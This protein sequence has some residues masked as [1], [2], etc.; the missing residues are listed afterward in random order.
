LDLPTEKA[1]RD[2]RGLRGFGHL[3]GTIPNRPNHD[4][5][6]S[7]PSERAVLIPVPA[8][9][10]GLVAIAGVIVGVTVMVMIVAM[11]VLMAL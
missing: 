1:R 11:A 10:R 9:R 8:T 5:P 3:P 4:A 6:A 7:L 2:D